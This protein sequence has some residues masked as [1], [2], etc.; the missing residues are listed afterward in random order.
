MS[1]FSTGIDSKAFSVSSCQ[2]LFVTF[3]L[4]LAMYYMFQTFDPS[5]TNTAYLTISSSRL[6]RKNPRTKYRMDMVSFT[7]SSRWVQCT[8]PCYLLGGI[9]IKQHKSKSSYHS[10]CLLT[11][12][13]ILW[14]VRK[15]EDRIQRIVGLANNHHESRTFSFEIWAKRC[16]ALYSAGG[17][18]TSVGRV[19]GWRSWTSGSQLL[20]T[21]SSYPWLMLLTSNLAFFSSLQ[22]QCRKDQS[23]GFQLWK[24]QVY[25]VCICTSVHWLT[26]VAD[27]NVVSHTE[28]GATLPP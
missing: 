25:E 5:L 13:R 12:Y 18:L 24:V 7:L 1:T 2:A 19:L 21:V 23:H 9:C 14:R 16:F 15:A 26:P 6:W 20:C 11:L 27:Q 4:C 3:A 22:L 17:V 10:A 28:N 8:S